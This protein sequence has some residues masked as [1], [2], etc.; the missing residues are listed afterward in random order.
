MSSSRSNRSTGADASVQTARSGIGLNGLNGAQRLNGLSEP[1]P[2]VRCKGCK[3][4]L[5][6]GKLVVGEIK[7]KCW[8]CGKLARFIA[9]NEDQAYNL[10]DG[11]G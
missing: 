3:A 6:D 11:Q 7:I 1:L 9:T 5:F 10:P 8:R 4:R 2:V